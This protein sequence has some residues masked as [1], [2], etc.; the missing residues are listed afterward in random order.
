M[1]MNT[2]VDTNVD[3][4]GMN[5]NTDR[6]APSDELKLLRNGCYIALPGGGEALVELT[7]G[8]YSIG[9]INREELGSNA[10]V[11]TNGAVADRYEYRFSWRLDTYINGEGNKYSETISLPVNKYRDIDSF[12]GLLVGAFK[13]RIVE[14]CGVIDLA[15][16]DRLM[17]KYGIFFEYLAMKLD[18]VK[19]NI[20]IITDIFEQ[21]VILP[22]HMLNMAKTKNISRPITRKK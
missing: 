15:L 3:K 16:S 22:V 11:S 1:N 12:R 6:V 9:G 20:S 21:P 17:D 13:D 8:L 5:T 14:R 18:D 7:W 2:N 4:L 10:A 19:N